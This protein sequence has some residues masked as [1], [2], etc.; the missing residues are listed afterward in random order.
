MHQARVA[1]GDE[2]SLDWKAPAGCPGRDQV[3][4]RV[5]TLTGAKVMAHAS[6]LSFRARVEQ[7]GDGS[8][9][10]ALT[11]VVAG[12]E[13]ARIVRGES[14]QAVAEAAS[15]IV[16]LA[17]REAPS[18]EP[19]RRPPHDQAGTAPVPSRAPAPRAARRTDEARRVRVAGTVHD[20]GEGGGPI[21]PSSLRLETGQDIS[22][23]RR[24][25][26]LF[27]LTGRDPLS[28][29]FG[30][31]FVTMAL[32]PATVAPSGF[33][34]DVLLGTQGLRGCVGL[35]RRVLVSSGCA[36][37]EA[38]ILWAKDEQSGAAFWWAAGLRLGLE[39]RVSGPFY[40]GL[41]V[42]GLVPLHQPTLRWSRRSVYVL[43]RVAQRG[44]A[45]IGLEVP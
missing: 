5:H 9:S 19:E 12:Q 16:A 39:A 44:W 10:L 4:A 43:D 15:V 33:K 22:T 23:F 35:G 26:G 42:E 32:W 8:W 29:V 14:C 34:A 6:D 38:G 28:R 11:R 3:L 24:P 40:V 18:T 21:T 31:E 27:A 17:V 45:G 1:R 30:L 25:V 37:T 13:H 7:L 20:S 2:L 36:V 41:A